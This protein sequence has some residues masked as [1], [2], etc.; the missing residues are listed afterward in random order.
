M[1][2]HNKF[3]FPDNRFEVHK[4]TIRSNNPFSASSEIDKNLG[5][6]VKCRHLN[7][8]NAAYQF[9]KTQYPFVESF[10]I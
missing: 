9:T 3:M 5:K 8:S 6:I 2:S 10:E 7:V 4:L 1:M